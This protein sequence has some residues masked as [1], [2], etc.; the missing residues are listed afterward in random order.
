MS[1]LGNKR[2]RRSRRLG[3]PSPDGKL[4]E[5]RIETPDPCN[6]TLTISNFRA[7]EN[8][9]CSKSENQLTEL[10]QISNE[11]QVWT[12]IMEENNNDR[13]TK[14]REEIDNKFEMILR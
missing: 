13:I 10:G 6:L 5:T 8:L 9:G 12:Q 11:I 2:N 1:E 14:M 4:S 7:Q 3:T